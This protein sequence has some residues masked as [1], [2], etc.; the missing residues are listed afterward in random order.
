MDLILK[1]NTPAPDSP[2]GWEKY[3]MP[4]GNSYLGGNVFGGV[5][6]ERIQI[7]EN[8]TENPGK[9]G[10]LNSFADILIHFPHDQEHTERYERGLDIGKA[11]AYVHYDWG[12]LHVERKYFASYP[13]RVLAGHITTSE[14]SDLAV[15]VQIPYLTEEEGREKRGSVRA[16]DDTIVMSGVMAGYNVHFEGQLRVFTNGTLEVVEN[17]LVVKGATDTWFI[18]GGATNYEL[19]PEIFMEWDD[20]KKLR[21]F[22]PHDLVCEIMEQ[23]AMHSLAELEKRHTEDY[24]NL[25]NRVSLELGENE[26]P[27]EMIDELLAAYS[28]GKRSRYLEVLYFQYGRYL[29]I[30]SSR[31]GALPANLQGVW[32]CHDRSPWG[33]GYWHNINVQMN[34]WPAFITNIAETFTA[35]LDF[36]LAF[37]KTAEVFAADFVRKTVP[38]K[39]SDKPGECGW[40]IGTGNYAYCISGPGRHSGPGTG[41][42]TTKLFWEYYDFTGDKKVLEEV[43]YPALLSMAKFFLRVVRE[44][45]G[46][47][48]SVFSA[49]PEQ[50][51]TNA[52]TNENEYYHTTGCAFDQQ[53]IWENANDMLK[54]VELIGEE[55]LPAEDIAVIKEVREQIGH[56]D[57]VQ[58]GWSG[59]I[60]EYREEKFYGDI[61]EYC[62]RHIS[63]LVGLYPGTSI[64]TETPAWLD[65]ARVTLN[66]RSDKST[67][68]ALAHRL[69]A[70]ART[71]DGNRT[72]RLYT[73]L[74]GMRTLPNLWDSHPPFQIDGN[75]GGTSGVAEMLLQS[76]ERYITPLACI[77]DEWTEGS[78]IGLVARG[79]FEVDVTWKAGCAIDITVRSKA[80]NVCRMKY[81]GIGKAKFDFDVVIIDEN[82]I[83]FTTQPGGTYHIMAIPAWKKEPYPVMLEADCDLR[84]KWDFNEPV[85]IWRAADSAPVY[86]LIAEKIT[87]G[88]YQDQSF[89]FG[90]AETVTYKITRADALNGADNGAYVTLNHSK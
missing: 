37:R 50:F 9:Y 87:G 58:V 80:G 8:S 17:K 59:Q 62:H 6:Y 7:T 73:N 27:A 32:N 19:R 78:Y 14:C 15:E 26:V 41:G 89:D 16:E 24:C 18:F 40:T 76:H 39:Y 86:T 84:L 33:S 68:W 22:D 55:N 56:Y 74:I 3:S 88:T 72:Y 81:N 46:K 71:G 70:W 77:P 82:H 69:N 48:L 65:A 13:D 85:N 20:R 66:H 30:A 90:K 57:P 11:F 83:E 60:K 47:Y 4:I 63:Q 79:G 61:G 28:Q 12:G 44:Y 45:D 36:N 53:M 21:E 75:F 1:Y 35:Y 67:G 34:Y 52:E 25:F 43:A 31:P 29:L 51:V 49:S 64:S 23:A 10:G 5:E 2:E 54:C 38:E 42:L